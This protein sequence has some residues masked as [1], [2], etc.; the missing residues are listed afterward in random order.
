[1]AMILA[2]WYDKKITPVET[3]KLAVD[4]G[5]RTYDSGTDWDFYKFCYNKY[6][7]FSKFIPTSSVTTLM[8]ALREG[9][10]AVCS[11]N[12]NDNHFF[13]TSGHFVVARGCDD[14]YIY[15]NDP[16]KEET[17][18]KHLATKSQKCLKQAFIFWPLTEKKTVKE[19]KKEEKP[20]TNLNLDGKIIDI[21]KYQGT[22]DFKTLQSNVSLVI[23]RVSSRTNKDPK[24]DE[25]VKEMKKYNIP[26]GVYHYSYADTKDKAI[27]E[28][29]KMYEYTKNYDPLF[30]VL[31][32]E[33][34][35]L[36]NSTIK[37]FV[38]ELRKYTEKRI[39][40]YVAH[41]RY[42]QYKYDELRSLFDFTWIPR[43]GTNNGTI[44]GATKPAYDCDLWQYT[45]TG[46]IGGINGHVDMNILMNEDKN[47]KWFLNI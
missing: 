36:T 8:A 38:K 20:S 3:S 2:T 11:M 22:I 4:N 23:A 27:E 42:N 24:I 1:M 25:Y 15:Y 29:K 5:Y 12:G 10:L 41:N 6:D 28:A 21:S 35:S 13:T 9:A 33:E 40:C 7:C 39:G 46:K 44:S 30:Y 45:S 26:F 37:T 19:E 17:P 31:D 47:I 34:A 14:K 43:Y 32:A 18:R 16:N